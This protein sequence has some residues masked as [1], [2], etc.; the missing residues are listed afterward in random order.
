MAQRITDKNIQAVVQAGESEELEYKAVLPPPDTLARLISAFANT[1]GGSIILG[2]E[3]NKRVPGVSYARARNHYERAC[4]LV[5]PCPHTALYRVSYRGKQVVVVDVEPS[6]EGPVA[7]GGTI[8]TRVGDSVRPAESQN[9]L[10]LI[11]SD[12]KHRGELAAQEAVARRLAE[13]SKMLEEIRQH[14]VMTARLRNRLPDLIVGALL[15]AILGAILGFL[16]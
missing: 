1:R 12:T 13:Q 7:V 4:N 2:L 3:G 9:V 10:S 11:K 16:L 5:S 6:H 15:G 8:L 14:Q